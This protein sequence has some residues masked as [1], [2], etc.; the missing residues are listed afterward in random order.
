MTGTTPDILTAALSYAVHG[1]AVLPIQ[2][3][4]KPPMGKLVP[5]GL[6]NATIDPTLLKYWWISEPRANVG[7][8]TGAISGLVVLDIDP[9]N[10]GEASLSKW[11]RH[12]GRMPATLE[13]LTGGGGRHLFF[14]HPGGHLSSK[15]IVPGLDLKADGGYVVA[16]PSR[17]PSGKLYEWKQ[18]AGLEDLVLAPLPQGLWRYLSSLTPDCTAARP[19]SEFRDVAMR[20][21]AEGQRNMWVARLV[22]HLLRKGVDPLVALYLIAAWNQVHNQPPLPRD[23]VIKTVN[24]IAGR[25]LRRRQGRCDHG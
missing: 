18:G 3:C 2:P 20:G 14:L 1:W 5:K 24:A 6:L 17:H 9:R 16:P 13:V 12:W 21:I 11:E 23:E 7:I 15:P 10:G 4:G 8:R 19:V 25:E 22:G